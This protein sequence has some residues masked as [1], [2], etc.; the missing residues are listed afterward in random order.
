MSHFQP[1]LIPGGSAGKESAQY[2]RPGFNPWV[3]KIPW[4]RERLPTPVFGPGDFHGLCSPLGRKE[5]DMTEWL[6]LLSLNNLGIPEIIV[7]TRD[8]K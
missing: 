6:S 8:G 5:S 7:V 3:G 2:R 1:V 4:R